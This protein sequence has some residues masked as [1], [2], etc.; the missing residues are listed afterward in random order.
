MRKHHEWGQTHHDEE[1]PPAVGQPVYDEMDN[2]VLKVGDGRRSCS[3][4]LRIY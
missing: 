4:L 1:E 3:A 2:H